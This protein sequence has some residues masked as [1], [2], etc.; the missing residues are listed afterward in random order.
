MS[1]DNENTRRCCNGNGNGIDVAV[2]VVSYSITT[3]TVIDAD[4]FPGSPFRGTACDIEAGDNLAGVVACLIED[5]FELV[6]NVAAMNTIDDVDSAVGH[7]TF[8][9]R[10]RR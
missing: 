5:G 7:Y 1:L 8:I 4:V 2:A 3:N 6:G 9:R 10:D